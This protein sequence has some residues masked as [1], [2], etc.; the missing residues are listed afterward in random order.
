MNA[1]DDILTAAI[2]LFSAH[3]YKGVSIREIATKADIHF[4]T[5]RHHFSSKEELYK[6]CISRHGES[7]L[8]SA[9]KFLGTD[10]KSKE[11]MKV[12]FR[13]A[14]EDVFRIHNENPFLTKLILQ[15]I[16][17]GSKN[18]DAVL[19]KTMLAMTEVFVHFFKACQKKKYL[20]IDVD[21]LFLTQSLMGTLH[22]F[23]RT[24]DIRERLLAHKSL[25]HKA[26]K[27]ELVENI[28][29]FYTGK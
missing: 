14:I 28:V 26:Y 6:A 22:H 23:M 25:K 4:A 24:E 8:E 2:E 13:L 11:D 17:T 10:P 7:R 16:E 5:I 9:Q 15:E 21:P 18:T 27:E 3:G 19:K 1:K 12:R 29:S 20:S